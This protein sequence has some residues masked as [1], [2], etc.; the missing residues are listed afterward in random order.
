MDAKT[1]VATT[2]PKLP[3]L[4]LPEG[5]LSEE[6]FRAIDRVREAL[7]AQA[8]GGLSP[9]SLTMAFMDWSIHLASAPGKCLEL[10][11]KA[12]QKAARLGAHIAA[13]GLDSDE[14][15]CIEPLPGDYRFT[16]EGWR[17]PPYNFWAQAFL[18]HQQWWHNVTHGVP[19]VTPHHED[20]VSFAARQCLDMFSPSNIPFANPEVVEKTIATGGQNFVQ[21]FRNWLEDASRVATQ[22]PP[23]GTEKFVVGKDVAV[24]PGKVVYRNRLIELIQY[25]PAT[26][27][28][29]AEPI[30][31]VPAWIMKYYILDLSPQN[32]LIRYLVGQGHT[33]FCISWLNP[34]ASDRSLIMDD[35]RRLGVMAALDAISAIVPGYK[36]H[37]SGYCL[38]GTLLAIS[39]AAMAR[40]GDDR[41]ASVTL[42]AAQTDFSEPGELALFIDDSQL[43]FLESMM[44]SKGY[45]SAD[46]MAGAFSLLRS[47]DLIWSRLVHDY[48]MGERT[49]MIDL[50]AWNADSTRMPYKMHSE[51]LEKL[52]LRNELAAGCFMVDGRPAALQNIRA[53]M[54]VVATERD[55]VA[56]WRSVYKI[57][58]L[59][60]T[61]VT[62][63]LTSGGHNAGIVSEPGH[64][65]R[66]FRTAL[67]HNADTCLGPDEWVSAA[68]QKAGSWWVDWQNWLAGHSSQERVRPPVM[69][70]ADKGYAPV[71]EAPGTYV[72]QR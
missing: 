59:A 13:A 61:D 52:Y 26:E 2:K 54:F 72:F 51:Y 9:A 16:N 21:G 48:L 28:V 5:R 62:F 7:T 24:T 40:T 4:P 50:M 64:S 57:H 8:T 25:S 42:L 45:L 14:P 41:L 12:S 68:T 3:K 18:L 32:S 56:P 63:V 29:F 34:G 55:H 22:Q 1:G 71:S 38:G 44:W 27:T 60:D 19:G 46:Q 39:A 6:K 58:Q 11:I 15:P 67:K 47:N 65:G 10:T 30:L 69:G 36:V 37:A 31:I 20:V 33:V 43:H 53:P 35:Y 23:V 70:A 17:K 66:R 49:P